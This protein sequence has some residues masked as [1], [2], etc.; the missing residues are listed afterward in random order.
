MQQ[1]ADHTKW[2][3]IDWEDASTAPTS[4][5]PHLQRETHAPRVFYDGHGAEVDIWGV[6]KLIMMNPISGLPQSLLDLGMKMVDGD[7]IT[8]EEG[9]EELKSLQFN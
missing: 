4:A 7:I 2:F 6:G 9:L 5:A 8:A 3:L 1:V